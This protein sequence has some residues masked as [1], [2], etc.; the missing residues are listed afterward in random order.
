[1]S[2]YLVI[3]ATLAMSA[4]SLFTQSRADDDDDPDPKTL[5]RLVADLGSD[6][7]RAREASMDALRKIG[8]AAVPFLRRQQNSADAEVRLR[9]LDLLADIEKKGQAFCFTGHVG[10]IIGLA[11]LPG[12]KKA[13]SAGEDKSIRLWDLTSG[14]EVSR[15]DGHAKPVWALAV[16]PGGRSFASSG[17]DGVIRLWNL[18][19]DPQPR[20]LA[21][22]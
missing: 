11:L 9:A 15:F 8:D 12:D 16:A 14:N 10:G 4:A 2:P 5:E 13:L 7:F 19:G 17:P 18:D 20:E 22:L 6:D 3:P 21:T 1:M